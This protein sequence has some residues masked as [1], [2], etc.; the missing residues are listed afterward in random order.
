M[1]VPNGKKAY[2]LQNR[3][4]DGDAERYQVPRPRITACKVGFL[5]AD[6]D[7]LCRPH[8]TAT[9]LVYIVYYIIILYT[10]IV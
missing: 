7:I 3:Y 6:G 4:A 2:E 1:Y 8:L 9:Q 10:G 5:H